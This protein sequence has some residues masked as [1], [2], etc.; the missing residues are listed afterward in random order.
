MLTDSQPYL[1]IEELRAIYHNMYT[2]S[3]TKLLYKK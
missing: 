1:I 3:R 2:T